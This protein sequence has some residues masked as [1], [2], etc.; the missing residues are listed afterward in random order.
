M[1]ERAHVTV[2]D[3]HQTFTY[4]FK[5]RLHPNLERMF[6][7]YSGAIDEER[8]IATIRS[9]APRLA[10][11]GLRLAGSRDWRIVRLIDR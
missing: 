1:V 4:L 5:E 6:A 8:L 3:I 9:Q 11:L 2:G 7:V 10:H